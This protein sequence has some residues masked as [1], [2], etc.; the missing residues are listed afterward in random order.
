M[1]K[2][3]I[4]LILAVVLTAGNLGSV[5]VMAAET[6]ETE[7][8][9]QEETVAAAE[10]SENTEE[11]AAAEKAETEEDEKAGEAEMVES[12]AEVSE[13][14]D[15]EE[16]DKAETDTERHPLPHIRRCSFLSC[17][18]QYHGHRQRTEES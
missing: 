11:T 12:R 4:A 13:E 18:I 8:T 7:E 9:A 14:A 6:V 3:V 16:T 1:K 5:P 17:A 2:N 15:P 10:D